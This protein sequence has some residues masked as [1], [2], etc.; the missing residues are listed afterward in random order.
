MQGRTRAI[1]SPGFE[2][3]VDTRF[4]E[5]QSGNAEIRS[6]IK[7]REGF[8]FLPFAGAFFYY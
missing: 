3:S 2:A 5:L 6:E 7:D 4:A 8:P 1:R